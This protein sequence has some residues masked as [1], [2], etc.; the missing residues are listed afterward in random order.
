MPK[1]ALAF[2]RVSTDTGP[3]SFRCAGTSPV[4]NPSCPQSCLER[5]RDCLRPWPLRTASAGPWSYFAALRAYTSTRRSAPEP[6]LAG[7]L[8]RVWV[9]NRGGRSDDGRRLRGSARGLPCGPWAQT[10]VLVMNIN[11]DGSLSGKWSRRTDRGYRAPRGGK[12]HRSASR[13]FRRGCEVQGSR[14]LM[15]FG[16]YQRRRNGDVQ[17]SSENKIPCLST[18]RSE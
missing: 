18:V 8:E 7:A 12:R 1:F 5:R 11:T 13:G 10:A 16:F 14:Y 17:T 2:S 9:Q 15:S 6:F 3:K 4:L